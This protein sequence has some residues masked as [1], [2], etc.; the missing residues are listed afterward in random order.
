MQCFVN[1]KE[2]EE[3]KDVAKRAYESVKKQRHVT[4]ASQTWKHGAI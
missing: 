4:P 1:I 3:E 2:E